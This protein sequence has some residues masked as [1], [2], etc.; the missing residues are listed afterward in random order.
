MASCKILG[1]MIIF[2]PLGFQWIK[3]GSKCCS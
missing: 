1:P 2:L 3:D